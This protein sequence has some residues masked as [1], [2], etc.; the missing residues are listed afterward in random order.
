M[1]P[2][3]E[4]GWEERAGADS[5][6]VM[7]EPAVR[8]MLVV[9]QRSDAFEDAWPALARDSGLELAQVTDAS[10]WPSP[11]NV[12]AVVVVVA[13]VEARVADALAGL[14][15]ASRI[16]AAAGADDDRR[17]AVA[18]V[19]AG[20]G[21]YFALPMDLAM[22]RAWLEDRAADRTRDERARALAREERTRYDFGR[23][24][25]ESPGLRAALERAARVIPRGSATILITGETGTGKELIAQAIHYN[26]PRA[27]QPFVE[28]NCSALPA[29]LLEA[30]LFGYEKGAFTGA[31]AAK[32]GLFEAAHR[33]TLFLDEIGE[34]PLELQAKL[35]RALESRSVRRVG[36]VQT[37]QVDVRVVAATHRDLGAEVRAG[38]FRE[39]LFYRLNVLPIH[40]PALRDR[41]E[42][43]LLLAD[44]FLT[45]FADEYGL[46]SPAIDA[47]VRRA[48]LSHPWPGNVR[49][50]RN[51]IERAVLLGEGALTVADLFQEGTGAPITAAAS[52]GA[53]PFPATMDEIERTAARA[54]I[55][56]FDGNKSAAADALGISRSRLYRLIGEAE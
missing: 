51:S 38:R 45:R 17:V 24:I 5:F 22:L 16:T 12:A 7:N 8:P 32:P 41:G 28:V 9:V 44:H 46:A 25:G 14:P 19:R 20:A 42:D 37:V 10:E 53:I 47:E 23:M 34:I 13:G 55:E 3:D 1:P 27:S 6:P 43:V 18:A 15:Y 33:G 39:D 49:E 30:E 21:D 36:S 26:G 54:M 31:V 40:L 4:Q 56:R 11:A 48:L 35:L 50:L 29:N 52:G 2:Q